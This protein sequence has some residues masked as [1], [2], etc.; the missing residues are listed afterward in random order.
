[1]WENTKGVNCRNQSS[2]GTMLEAGSHMKNLHHYPS[3]FSRGGD[4]E[5]RLTTARPVL[6]IEN[7]VDGPGRQERKCECRG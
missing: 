5:E 1:M 2:S 6:G 3:L 4:G 7:A